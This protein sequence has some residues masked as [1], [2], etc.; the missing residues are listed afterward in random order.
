MPLIWKFCS[1]VCLGFLLCIAQLY[2]AQGNYNVALVDRFYPGDDY[3]YTNDDK[4]LHIALYGMLDLDRDGN[5]E[6]LY[7]GDIVKRILKHPYINVISY[8][9]SPNS[10]PIEGLLEQ[11]EAIRRDLFW[12]E[13]IDAVLLPWESSTLISAFGEDL[14]R[15]NVDYYMEE[16]R[17]WGSQ[18]SSWKTTLEIIQVL[19]DIVDYGGKVFTIAGNGGKRMVNTYSFARGVTTVGASEPELTHF[20]AN[21]TFVDEYAPAAYTPIRLDDYAGYAIG[22]DLDGDSCSDIALNELS[23]AG[24]KLPKSHWKPLLGSSF[25]APAA[26]KKFVLGYS[27]MLDCQ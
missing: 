12:E 9:L 14:K 6:P 26:L 17:S 7:H 21:N 13:P 5:K 19:E 22:Y 10:L 2:A 11:L 8:K 24:N 25:A 15:E 23:G 3:F 20:I 27:S 18:D 4:A 1:K 16:L